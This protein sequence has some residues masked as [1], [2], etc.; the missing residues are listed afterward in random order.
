MLLALT[1]AALAA[2]PVET[3]A[4]EIL[5]QL[6]RVDT[7]HG[8]ES[9]ALQPLVP[10]FQSAGV[11]AQISGPAVPPTAPTSAARSAGSATA[12]GSSEN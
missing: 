2:G 9:K 3:E 5:D 11:Q 12:S 8:N 1:C 4:R 6:L 10:R 7:S